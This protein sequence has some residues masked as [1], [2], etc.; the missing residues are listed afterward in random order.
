[1]DS[2][3]GAGAYRRS[4]EAARQSSDPQLMATVLHNIGGLAHSRERYAEAE[5]PARQAWELWMSVLGAD[6]PAAIADS[7]AYA[8]AGQTP[9]SGK[10]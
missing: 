1:M 5:D 9:D 4:L 6:H 2:T 7:V 3:G 8:A 10:S